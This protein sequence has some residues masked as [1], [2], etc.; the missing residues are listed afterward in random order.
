M[1]EPDFEISDIVF[2]G[3]EVDRMQSAQRGAG[4]VVIKIVGEC[5]CDGL[6]SYEYYI[7]TDTGEVQHFMESELRGAKDV[8]LTFKLL[9]QQNAALQEMKHKAESAALDALTQTSVSPNMVGAVTGR[10]STGAE[11]KIKQRAEWP[12]IFKNPS[13][14]FDPDA[15]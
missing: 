13:K 6:W 4:A 1:N 5:V 7:R 3:L 8:E 12:T 2:R 9:D 11:M 14:L 15:F 10:H